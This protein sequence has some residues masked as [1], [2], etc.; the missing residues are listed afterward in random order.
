MET[1]K[2]REGEGNRGPM[3]EKEKAEWWGGA[4]RRIRDRLRKCFE[5]SKEGGEKLQCAR[6][7]LFPMI[8]RRI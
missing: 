5:L 2:E 6:I 8:K 1:G 4:D 7:V 3:T